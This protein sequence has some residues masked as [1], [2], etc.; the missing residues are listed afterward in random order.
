MSPAA[1]RLRE[2]LLGRLPAAP[3]E[4]PLALEV[5]ESNL[6]DE[7]AMGSLT[8]SDREAFE[9]H[10]LSNEDRRERLA[11]AKGIVKLSARRRNRRRLLT[12][13]A[14]TA[15]AALIAI[16]VFPTAERP[17]LT[18]EANATRGT[19]VP[20]FSLKAAPSTLLLELKVPEPPPACTATVTRIGDS[21]PLLTIQVPKRDLPIVRIA[22]EK[23]TLTTGDYSVTLSSGTQF[24]QD[25]VFHVVD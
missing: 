6:I 18:L 19:A 8:Q 23:S 14:T 10:F 1:D 15:V 21:A 7:Y 20:G 2:Y 3:N 5:A 13:V 25:F 12:A 22:F 11:M 24:H 16:I 17:Y 9:K 4:D